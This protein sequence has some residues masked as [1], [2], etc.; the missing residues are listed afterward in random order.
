MFKGEV[1]LQVM[2]HY[3]LVLKLLDVEQE[4]TVKKKKNNNLS[5]SGFIMQ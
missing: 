2:I 4:L 5:V 3:N 1:D